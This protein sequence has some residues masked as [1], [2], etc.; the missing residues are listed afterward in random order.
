MRR[1]TATPRNVA[2]TLTHA[3]CLGEWVGEGEREG[4]RERRREMEKSGR[5]NGGRER[6]MYFTCIHIQLER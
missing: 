6:V 2:S 4:V 1:Y 5:D 3:P